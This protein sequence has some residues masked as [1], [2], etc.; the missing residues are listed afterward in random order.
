MTR[1][2]I[3]DQIAKEFDVRWAH[4]KGLDVDFYD[5]MI[6]PYRFAFIGVLLMDDKTLLTDFADLAD[7]T[8]LTDEELYNL[9]VKHNL[10]W[11]DYNI[12]LEYHSNED[13]KRYKKF[14]LDVARLNWKKFGKEEEFLALDE[15]KK[16]M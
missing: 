13:I 11:N 3:F 1:Q 15:T 16:N 14:L 5:V 10:V 9:C 2:E 4:S 6:D 12:E 7:K 8:R